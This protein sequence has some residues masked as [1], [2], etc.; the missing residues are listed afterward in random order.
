VYS[1]SQGCHTATGTHMV[2]HGITQCYLPPGRGD[3][4]ALTP[5]A[6]AGT[7]LSDPGWMQGWVDLM[8]VTTAI[9]AKTDEPIKMPFGMWT[10][11]VKE[12]SIRG[13][14]CLRGRAFYGAML[15]HRPTQIYPRSIWEQLAPNL[16]ENNRL[17]QNQKHD[18]QQTAQLVKALHDNYILNLIR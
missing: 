16:P 14:N 5:S 7:R 6:E 4:S 18:N 17:Q 15:G 12:P 9:P 1:S 10:R 3:I 8:L 13:P 2:P 11:G